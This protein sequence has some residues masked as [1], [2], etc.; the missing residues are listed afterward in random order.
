MRAGQRVYIKPASTLAREWRLPPRTEGVVLCAYEVLG[1]F[2]TNRER[3]DVRL[4]A[5]DVAWGISTD[6]IEPA[7]AGAAKPPERRR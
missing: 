4:S 6:Q 7:P 3:V 5:G 2:S 1:G